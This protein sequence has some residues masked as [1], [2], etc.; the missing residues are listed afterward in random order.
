MPRVRQR[1]KGREVAVAAKGSTWDSCSKTVLYLESSGA[2]TN[3]HVRENCIEQSMYTHMN[4]CVQNWYNIELTDYTNVNFSVVIFIYIYARCYPW[5]NLGDGH[6][7][8]LC[9]ISQNCI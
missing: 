8:S 3:L 2:F 5:G 9:I 7:E 6:R 4:E 1:G